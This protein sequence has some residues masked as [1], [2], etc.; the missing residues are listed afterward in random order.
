[1][2][3]IE[4]AKS[5]VS[6]QTQ[7]RPGSA[8]YVQA[9]EDTLL[10]Q[11]AKVFGLR[12][13]P[14]LRP[15]A[16]APPASEVQKAVRQELAA[17]SSVRRDPTW[18]K[19]HTKWMTEVLKQPNPMRVLGG[20]SA[21]DTEFLDCVAVMSNPQKSPSCLCSGTLIGKNVV[22]TAAHCVVD[23]CA[24]RVFIG[25]N[26]NVLNSGVFI[27]IKT[28]IPHPQYDSL[29]GSHD[30]AVLILERDADGEV[31]ALTSKSGKVVV[32]IRELATK[33]EIDGA[34]Y[35]EVV[36]F[37]VTTLLL[38]QSG[39]KTKVQL[40]IA[41][42][43]CT[44]SGSDK[45]G[46]NNGSELVAGGNGYDSCHGDSGG[47]AYVPVGTGYKLAGVTSRGT[48]NSVTDCGDGGIYTRV[49]AYTDWITQTVQA[50]GGRLR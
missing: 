29:S 46:C 6:G 11:K 34:S 7:Y 35:V 12:M 10:Q 45:Y 37:G 21:G 41:S 47:P 20:D 36:G 33:T 23:G 13:P 31:K 42:V 48:S 26:S 44:D 17:M 25:S 14:P 50:K 32:P 4:A 2:L 8:A 1:V 27:P 24:D 15:I 5:S 16:P 9:L 40:P 30:L 28:S 3:L 49:D 19:N 18:L 22:L 43:A 39:I 38:Q